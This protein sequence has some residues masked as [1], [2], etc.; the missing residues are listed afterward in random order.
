MQCSAVL[1]RSLNFFLH[2]ENEIMDPHGVSISVLVMGWVV[3][4][5]NSHG[6]GD[7]LLCMDEACCAWW[8][9]REETTSLG[10]QTVEAWKAVIFLESAVTS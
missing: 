10:F 8:A 9:R 5:Q 2:E 1:S 7:I 6:H 4:L 3:S